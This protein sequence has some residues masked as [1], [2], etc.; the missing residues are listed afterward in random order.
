MASNG[1]D[2][3][4]GVHEI[5]L[6]WESDSLLDVVW[7]CEWVGNLSGFAES[8]EFDGLGVLGIIDEIIVGRLVERDV[9]LGGEIIIVIFVDIEM[10]G[11]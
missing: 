10:V 1:G 6:A 2:S 5:V 8:G 7:G 11:F 9:S 3:G 4:E